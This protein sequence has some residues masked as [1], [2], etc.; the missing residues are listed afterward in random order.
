MHRSVIDTNGYL[1]SGD[2]KILSNQVERSDGCA[3]IV[4]IS[5]LPNECIIIG[6]VVSQAEVGPVLQE[7]R[8]LGNIIAAIMKFYRQALPF[9]RKYYRRQEI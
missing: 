7:I 4:R 5:C 2:T 9:P 3:A 6:F 8:S 1:H